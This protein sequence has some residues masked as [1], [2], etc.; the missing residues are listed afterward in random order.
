MSDLTHKLPD[1]LITTSCLLLELSNKGK[2][3]FN[4]L[5]IITETKCR[6]CQPSY[7]LVVNTQAFFKIKHQME[8][9]CF[10]F[11]LVLIYWFNYNKAHLMD[12]AFF[13]RNIKYSVR[14]FS[15]FMKYFS[16]HCHDIFS[17]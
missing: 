5:S 17:E 13:K 7:H 11:S 4:F 14:E 1:F 8:T 15:S 6:Q 12:F 10:F 2:T 3:L 16:T 9:S